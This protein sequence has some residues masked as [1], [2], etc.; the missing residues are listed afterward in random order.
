VELSDRVVKATG[1]DL[2]EIVHTAA[3]EV[4]AH[5]SVQL[6]RTPA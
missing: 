4:I 3:E 1:F 6:S 5:K 2:E